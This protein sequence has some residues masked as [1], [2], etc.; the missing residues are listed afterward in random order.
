MRRQVT[1]ALVRQGEPGGDAWPMRLINAGAPKRAL[2]TIMLIQSVASN[3]SFYGSPIDVKLLYAADFRVRMGRGTATAFTT[4]PLIRVEKSY[5]SAMPGPQDWVTGWEVQ[6]AIGA[7]I[8]SQAQSSGGAAG[9]ISITLAA[10]TNFAAGNYVFMHNTGIQLSEWARVL[11]VSSATLT[12][13]EP[14]VNSQSG[15]TCRNQAEQWNPYLDLS[16]V[17]WIRPVVDANSSGQAVIVQIDA[18]FVVR[19]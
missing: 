13:E 2:T 4:S 3:S 9:S 19:P 10:G 18:G 7:T 1:G 8:G 6:P 14:L 16:G 15:A 5:V 12:L 11:S 17:Q